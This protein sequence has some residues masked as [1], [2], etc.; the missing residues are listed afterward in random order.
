MLYLIQPNESARLEI[1][2]I[3]T[4]PVAKKQALDLD[5]IVK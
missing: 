2:K 3:H 5:S 1:L 4:R